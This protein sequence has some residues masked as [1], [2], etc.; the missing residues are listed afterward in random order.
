MKKNLALLAATI[1]LVGFNGQAQNPTAS[2]DSDPKV[3]SSTPL[4]LSKEAEEAGIDG[5]LTVALTVDK[6]GD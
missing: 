6:T 4:M 3:L 1:F 5:S 2:P